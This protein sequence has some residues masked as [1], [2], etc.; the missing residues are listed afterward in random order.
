MTWFMFSWILS[1]FT[2]EPE[3]QY[4]ECELSFG[5]RLCWIQKKTKLK[6]DF[7]LSNSSSC[8]TLKIFF[9]KFLQHRLDLTKENLQILFESHYT[10]IGRNMSWS[11]SLEDHRICTEDGVETVDIIHIVLLIRW[12]VLCW[13]VI[14][15][16]ILT[17]YRLYL[18]YWMYTS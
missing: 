12:L 16:F 2:K 15:I 3:S 10:L 13:L 8:R 18:A 5:Q 4:S 7:S 11:P 6:T 17:L 14:I 1:L 9:S